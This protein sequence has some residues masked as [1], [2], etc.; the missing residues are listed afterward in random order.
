MNPKLSIITI[1]FNDASGLQKTIESVVNQ[2]FNSYEYIVIDGGSNDG[3]LDVIKKHADKIAYWVSEKDKGIYNAMN[4]GIKQAKGEYCLFLNSGDFLCNKKVIESVFNGKCTE[5]IIYGN[6]IID[7][8]NGKKTKGK[9]PDIITPL[10]MY[11]DTLWHPVSFI[12]RALFDKYGYYNENY[13]IV[14]DYD[15]FFKTIIAHKVSTKHLPLFISE[16]NVNGL[17]SKPENKIL[18]KNERKQVIQSYLSAQEIEVLEQQA[19][20][21]PKKENK[22]IKAFLK[23]WF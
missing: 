6:M 4:K 16:Y 21:M 18:E 9:M 5:D 11:T 3:S 17:S 23:K 13:K 8:S 2:S 19:Q 1:N 12:K 14:S 22:S 20:L 15:F 7:W 10:Q